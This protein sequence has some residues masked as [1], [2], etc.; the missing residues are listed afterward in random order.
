M[1]R[2]HASEAG[3]TLIEVL[4]V[5]LIIGVMIGVA[6]VNLAR[7][8]EDRARE[9]SEH[10]A[11]LL[12]AAREE[13]ILQGRVYAFAADAGGYRFLRLETDGRLKP[14]AD[15]VLRPHELPAGV[16]MAALSID[17]ADGA[18]RD[19][20]VFVPSGE[21]PQFRFVLAGGRVRWSVVGAPDGSIRTQAGS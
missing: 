6:G 15:D 14:L 1:Q 21:L 17:G 7:G 11:M 5:V 20:L 2:R 3:F 13:A 12:R 4:V 19:G 16:A 18:A 10:L 9:E 8:P